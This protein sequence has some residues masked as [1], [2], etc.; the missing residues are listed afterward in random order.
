[1][2]QEKAPATHRSYFV[3]FTKSFLDIK[4]VRIT[5]ILNILIMLF[6][7]KFGIIGETPGH[8]LRTTLVGVFVAQFLEFNSQI[9]KRRNKDD[10]DRPT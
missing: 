2:D 5:V 3:D 4:V 6:N 9:A 1:M 8:F 10:E 7:L